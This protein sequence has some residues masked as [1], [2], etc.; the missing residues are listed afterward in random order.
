MP[1][2]NDDV[3]AFLLISAWSVATGRQLRSDVPPTELTAG[4]LVDFWTDD[5]LWPALPWDDR[6]ARCQGR[7]IRS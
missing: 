1:V 5:H 2:T 6:S 3:V 7:G 4:E